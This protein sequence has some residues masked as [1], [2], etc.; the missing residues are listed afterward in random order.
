MNP[1]LESEDPPINDVWHRIIKYAR[2][3]PGAEHDFAE[4]ETNRQ[5]CL[6]GNLSGEL[7]EKYK[8]IAGAA[9]KR[10]IA[11]FGE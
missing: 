9:A 3:V 1:F 7:R 6:D 5:L 2:V 8:G 10:I 4:Y 11:R